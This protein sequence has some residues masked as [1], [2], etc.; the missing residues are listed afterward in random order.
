M[1]S[2]EKTGEILRY[3]AISLHI[4]RVHITHHLS[5]VGC[6]KQNVWGLQSVTYYAR[7][8]SIHFLSKQALD[9][10]VYRLVNRWF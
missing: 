9:F 7:G 3:I 1:S 4:S 10:M 6:I 5:N 2:A 8:T